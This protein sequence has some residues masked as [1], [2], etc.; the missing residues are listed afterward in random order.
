VAH[1]PAHVRGRPVY[2]AGLHTIDVLHAPAKRDRVAAVVPDNAFRLAG[3]AGGIEDI[4]GVRCLDRVQPTGFAFAISSSQSRSRPAMRGAFTIWPL[5]DDAFPRLVF[6]LLD[7]L[8]EE[9]LV[10]EEFLPL[11]RAGRSDHDLGPCVVDPDG[12]LVG[13]ESAEDHGVDRSQARAGQ[14]GNDG[15]GIM[16]M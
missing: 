1:D 7:R 13:R 4:E 5:E 14:H 6:G 9:G 16:G 12:E 11:D 3:R 8:V 2:I 15:L 10:F